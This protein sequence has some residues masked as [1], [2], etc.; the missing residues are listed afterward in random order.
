MSL[1]AFIT[2]AIFLFHIYILRIECV[3]WMLICE[4]M[5]WDV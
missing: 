2:I 4:C 3:S 1:S 5:E